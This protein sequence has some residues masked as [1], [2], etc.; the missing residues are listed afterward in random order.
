MVNSGLTGNYFNLGDVLSSMT[1]SV[2]S[3]S[4][5]A[6][7]GDDMMINKLLAMVDRNYLVSHFDQNSKFYKDLTAAS[8]SEE[9][10]RNTKHF[11]EL[12]SSLPNKIFKRSLL[13]IAADKT[14][15]VVN[16]KVTGEKIKI[17]FADLINSNGELEYDLTEAH[18]A[19][20]V[21]VY[22]KMATD[23][24]VYNND[25][26]KYN[27]NAI[28]KAILLFKSFMINV[29]NNH[30]KIDGY[31]VF[32]DEKERGILISIFGEKSVLRNEKGKFRN[33][34]DV[35][36]IGLS[37]IMGKAHSELKYNGDIK[38]IRSAMFRT[39]IA[40]GFMLVL[41]AMEGVI[42]DEEEKEGTDDEGNKYKYTKRTA[43]KQSFLSYNMLL[44]M[45]NESKMFV[46]PLHTTNNYYMMS[47]AQIKLINDF[48]N[49]LYFAF[50]QEVES[51]GEA[52]GQYKYMKYGANIVPVVRAK[53][54]WNHL[55]ERPFNGQN[56]Y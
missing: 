4:S 55:E 13:L 22:E 3:L 30:M 44:R 1:R 24:L 47:F 54:Q 26:T 21:S 10:Y 2:S 50:T 16:D 29:F 36:D 31:N 6:V 25:Y 9:S 28:H 33:I 34:K 56:N 53:Y 7:G 35:M 48:S 12:F 37:A 15:V 20:F 32:T 5:N 27:K 45:Y 23:V 40:L 46:D 41:S 38:N 19:R 17:K 14:Y 51:R 43:K 11:M 52:A 49:F 39:G 42:Y 18:I 8:S